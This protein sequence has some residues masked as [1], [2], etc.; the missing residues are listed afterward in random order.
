MNTTT[1]INT[2][3][4]PLAGMSKTAAMLFA[5][6]G[7]LIGAMTAQAQT[8]TNV[9]VDPSKYWQGW[10]NVF[11]ASGTKVLF[12]TN[13]DT[14]ALDANF[15]GGKVLVFTPSVRISKQSPTNAADP[16]WWNADGTGA[17]KMDASYYVNDDT[18]A[19]KF[20]TF[21]GYC[22]SNTLAAPY[23]NNITAFIK[24][25]DTNWNVKAS[26]TVKLTS[27]Q[28][29]SFALQTT[30]NH[31]VEYGFEMVG[32]NASSSNIASL[33]QVL[34]YS[35]S[36]APQLFTGPTT[37]APTP[38]RLPANVLSLYNSSGIYKDVTNINYWYKYDSN[39]LQHAT[40]SDFLIIGTGT[41]VKE[42]ANLE[43]AIVDCLGT[44]HIDAG[45]YDTLHVDVWT[46]NANQ[47]GVKLVST[48]DPDVNNEVGAEVDYIPWNEQVT[49]ISNGWVSLDIPLSRFLALP[50][51]GDLDLRNIQEILW[52][53]NFQNRDES[54]VLSGVVSGTF[55]IDNVYF[56][57]HTAPNPGRLTID[58]T[59]AWLTW[60]IL[61]PA[62]EP[63]TDQWFSGPRP[64]SEL[65]AGFTN[66]V[67]CLAP[68]TVEYGLRETINSDGTSTK[69]AA[70]DFYVE[71]K[72][73]LAGK[74]VTFVGY[75]QSNSLQPNYI[76]QAWVKELDSNYSYPP[77]HEI[78]T[79]LVSH[80]NF[81]L[82]L[83]S[84]SSA[85]IVQY[86]FTIKG[87]VANPVNASALGQALVSIIPPSLMVTRT[88]TISKL[89]F[90]MEFGYK[91]TPQYKT[92]LSDFW[93]DLPFVIGSGSTTN[94]TN[95]IGAA[96]RFYRL[97]IH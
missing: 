5:A 15:Q 31:H 53:D 33:G 73:G 17:R 86:G 58:P 43:Y 91:Y 77:I 83:P 66:G 63:E 21:S 32:P 97:Y 81:T 50:N 16:S 76:A 35:N 12:G 93:H 6:G 18:L 80:T 22:L 78:R 49:I 87:P 56:C 25:L 39:S 30:N 20:V 1:L 79:N 90:P 13:W 40:G 84:T 59:A 3:R 14:S 2:C 48:P 8:A 74:S 54:G 45:A 68:N 36:I 4:S 71:P 46:P 47:F 57:T 70:G 19:G 27:G 51:T 41:T 52:T 85:N 38:S 89:S 95:S 62:T 88:N 75:C 34:V 65:K 82:T 9:T 94:V 26:I 42:Y 92:N 24:D 44:N 61:S 37:G 55:Y 10:M 64:P 67:L 96:Q 69:Y 28:S 23:S 11:P 72:S 60:E 7:L 29:F